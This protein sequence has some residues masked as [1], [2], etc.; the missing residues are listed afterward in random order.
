MEKLEERQLRARP[1]NGTYS[2]KERIAADK[3]DSLAIKRKL[4]TS[5]DSFNPDA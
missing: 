4:E 2:K 3:I 1:P 5:I